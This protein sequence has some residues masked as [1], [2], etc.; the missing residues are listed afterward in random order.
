MEGPVIRISC[1]GLQ[2]FFLCVYKEHNFN[3]KSQN[4]AGNPSTAFFFEGRLIAFK[5]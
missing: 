2:I 1:G 5:F 4:I 3:T